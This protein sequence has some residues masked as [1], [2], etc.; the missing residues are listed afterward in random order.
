MKKFFH[1]KLVLVLLAAVLLTGGCAVGSVVLSDSTSPVSN[2]LGVIASP[3]RTAASAFV[4]WVEGMYDYAFRYQAMEERV[5]ELEAELAEVESN[6]REYEETLKENE[7][8]RELL[9]LAKRR[10]DFSFAMAS[11]TGRST[12]SWESTLTLSKGT[13]DNIAIGDCVIT[14]TGALVGVVA[15]AGLNWCTVTTIIDPAISMGVV[16]YRSD[17]AAVLESDLTTM[18]EGLCRLSY[19]TED[20]D[21]EAGDLILTSGASGIYPSGLVVGTLT[22][23]GYTSAGIER[24]ALVEP[25]ASL[26]NLTQ[27]FVVLDFDISE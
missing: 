26:T 4:N 2:A 21:V 20:S 6:A 23:V 1:S 17:S 27:V 14:Q 5:A 24:Y 19:L 15:E 11:V 18:T 9:E 22:E 10:T 8:L 16:D 7:R 25:E 3:F 12:T 13:A